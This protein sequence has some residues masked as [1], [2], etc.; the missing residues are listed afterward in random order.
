MQE[1]KRTAPEQPGEV[2]LERDRTAGVE[3]GDPGGVRTAISNV[4]VGLKKDFY[5]KGP[6]RVKTYL[7]DNYVFCVLEDGLTRN[8]ETLL[9]AG[10]AH[11]VRQ[12]RL[13]FQEAMQKPT[14]EALEKVTGRKVLGYHSQIIFEPPRTFEI[15]VLDEPLVPSR[16]G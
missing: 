12:F 2:L 13:R 10:E 1:R 16:D 3:V 11:L 15:I 5:G 6:S 4:M 14:I 8:E 9:E 7:N